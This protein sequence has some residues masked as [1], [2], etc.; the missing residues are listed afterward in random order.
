MLLLLASLTACDRSLPDR[1]AEFS[2]FGSSLE[3]QLRDTA[4][5]QADRAIAAVGAAMQQLHRN[6]HPWEPGPL[7]TLNAALAE[8]RSAAVD[9]EL[10]ELVSA[11][12]A[13]EQA[14]LGFFNPAIGGLIRLWG[15]HTS[16]YPITSPPPER[17]AIAAWLP[18]PSMK[19][20]RFEGRQLASS[21]PRVQLDFSGL[22]KGL[23]V[24]E[25][26]RILAEQGIDQAM[27]NAGGDVGICGAGKRAWKVA[28][29]APAGGVF[30][31]VEIDRP[32]AVF[33][34]GNYHRYREFDGQRWAHLL[35]PATG[36]PVDSIVQATV[37]DA[38]PLKADAAA[39]ALVV[40]G[41]ERWREVA[42]AMDVDQAL[43]IDP[44]GQAHRFGFD[45]TP[46]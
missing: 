4:P 28:I 32:M 33:T 46:H 42:A 37:I 15:F 40:A 34:S 6:L 14:S 18:A 39:T 31:V 43:V 29:R 12:A 17:S 5:D 27:I 35:D 24:R 23:A 22:A 16:D 44:Q 7:S 20:L 11:G 3:L 10:A 36:Q 41:L 45:G 38:D 30:E 19:A 9:A 26:C 1:S 25:A 21:D 2:V 13:L 8:G